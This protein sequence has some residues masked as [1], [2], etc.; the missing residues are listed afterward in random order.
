MEVS[1]LVRTLLAKRGIESDTDVAAFLNPD[2]VAHT[3]DP[4]LLSG[5][6]AALARFFAAFDAGERIAVYTDYDCDGIGAAV[7]FSDFLNKIC[8]A[9]FEVYMPHRDLEG[10][11]FHPAAVEKLA[12]S[13]AK[14]I[15]T[16]DVGISGTPATNRAKELGVDVIITDHH[17]AMVDLP[18]A[19]AVINPKLGSYPFPHLC[20][21][22]VAFKFVQAALAE[23]RRRSLPQFLAIPEGWEKWLL[24]AVAV[25]TISDMV[26]LTGENRTLLHFGLQVLRKSPRPGL[27]ALCEVAR[28][29]QRSISEDDVGFAI[30]PR[31]NA[32]SRMGEPRLA[33]DLLTTQDSAEA[34]IIARKLEALNKER[35]TT[36]AVMVKQ[37]KKRSRE[38]FTEN[39]LVAVLGDAA[40]KPSLLGLAANSLMRERG[41][42]VCLWGRD[43]TGAL[44]GSC[45]SD[46]AIS[47]VDLFGNSGDVFTQYG[48]HARSG[49]FTV[50]HE[51]VHTLPEELARAGQAAARTSLA[52]SVAHD[53]ALTLAAISYEFFSD[54]SRLAPF[55]ME[56]PKPVFLI[57]EAR[58]GVVRTFG[59]EKNHVEVM[60][61][62]E[63]TAKVV[64]AFEFFKGPEQFSQPPV[65]GASAQVLATLERDSF[66]GPQAL[67]LRIVDFLPPC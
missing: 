46:G 42:V 50:S 13:G 66:K 31:L 56:N 53:V 27:R 26:P 39:D 15:I 43:A 58:I 61:E 62:C 21:A 23:G 45:R 64:R 2:Y 5:M 8:Y 6:E 48:G 3:H 12:A 41:G 40:W 55:G 63:R 51:R 20:G 60:L 28:I 9:N 52:Q 59:K 1:D 4:M 44:K 38:R 17:E 34:F 36:V 47:L 19:L 16:A 29:N 57:P 32:A 25:A 18:L 24:D 7:V 22:A 10:Y 11:G 33:F 67:A 14:L 65:Q 49:G 30:A 54:F 35:K 37:A